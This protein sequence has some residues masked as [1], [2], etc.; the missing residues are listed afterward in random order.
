M[1]AVA[2]SRDTLQTRLQ[3]QKKLRARRFAPR[4]DEI[5]TSEINSGQSGFPHLRI[6][7]DGFGLL[8]G[9]AIRAV[10]QCKQPREIPLY[11]IMSSR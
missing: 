9:V 3:K 7:A 4:N 10:W 1:E 2:T 6:S 11:A 5:E 8:S